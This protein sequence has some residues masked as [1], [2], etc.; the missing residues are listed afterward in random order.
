MSTLQED[1]CKRLIDYNCHGPTM[2]WPVVG[3]LMVEPTESESLKEL[4]KYRVKCCLSVFDCFEFVVVV[5]RHDQHPRLLLNYCAHH[6][7][8]PH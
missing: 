8:L 3:T 6:F 2:S 4:G 7:P 5:R 1:V